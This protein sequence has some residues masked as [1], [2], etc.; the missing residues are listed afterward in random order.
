[1]EKGADVKIAT[2]LQDIGERDA[3]DSGRSVAPLKQD[4]DSSFI[5]T[6]LLN[7]TE[8]VNQILRLYAGICT[9]NVWYK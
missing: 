3:R 2:I 4:A 5:D 9:K 8:V 1:M 6:T 7:I